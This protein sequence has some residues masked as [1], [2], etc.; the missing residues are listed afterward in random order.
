MVEMLHIAQLNTL[1]SSVYIL[2]KCV[3]S[4]FCLLILY[5]PITRL[6]LHCQCVT[7]CWDKLLLCA[8]WCYEAQQALSVNRGQHHV[9]KYACSSDSYQTFIVSITHIYNII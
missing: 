4:L 8:V 7:L 3:T 5:I 6:K 2:T 1:A 9:T